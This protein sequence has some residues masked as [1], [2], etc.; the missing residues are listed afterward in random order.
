MNLLG[1]VCQARPFTADGRGRLGSC[2][3]LLL[4]AEERA[5][6]CSFLGAIDEKGGRLSRARLPT[7]VNRLTDTTTAGGGRGR[8]V[9][10]V[11][12]TSNNGRCEYIAEVESPPRSPAGACGRW[13]TSG[14]RS[15]TP[16][17]VCAGAGTR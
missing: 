4:A 3:R 8:S 9:H 1:G 7:A 10:D 16:L 12:L 2:R 17:G 13:G 5:N 15:E 6:D 11:P 14:S